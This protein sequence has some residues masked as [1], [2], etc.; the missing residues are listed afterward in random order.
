[1]CPNVALRS[2]PGK[3]VVIQCNLLTTNV[4]VPDPKKDVAVPRLIK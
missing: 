4:A 3:T 2:D 1:M